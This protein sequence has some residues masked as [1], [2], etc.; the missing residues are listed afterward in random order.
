MYN[1]V[2]DADG[3]GFL[4]ILFATEIP[5]G[6]TP[7]VLTM[8]RNLGG[9]L[10]DDAATPS[11]I[12]LTVGGPTA[13]A[14][15]DNDGCDDFVMYT[16]G[17]PPWIPE[18]LSVHIS[19][20]TYPFSFTPAFTMPSPAAFTW[21][22][23]ADIDG[24][25]GENDFVMRASSSRI[26]TFYGS[27]SGI[28][29]TGPV[30]YDSGR[31]G[32]LSLA[33]FYV[34]DVDGDTKNDI[35]FCVENWPSISG[36]SCILDA[37]DASFGGSNHVILASNS[38]L[39]SVKALAWAS[40]T[41]D[42]KP[43]LV[44]ATST[45]GSEPNAIVYFPSGPGAPG[46]PS[47]L[48]STV[49]YL[50][51]PTLPSS[52]YGWTNLLVADANGD[53][54]DD[55]FAG[56]TYLLLFP[57]DPPSFFALFD[58]A[59]V[60]IDHT[61]EDNTGLG[62]ENADFIDIGFI[63][64]NL[65]PDIMVASPSTGTIKW[66]TFGGDPDVRETPFALGQTIADPVPG[67]ILAALLADVDTDGDLD[68]VF[69]TPASV[70]FYPNV[71][72]DGRF[73]P[74]AVL[75]LS[76]MDP[77][78]TPSGTLAL[79]YHAASDTVS[80]VSVASSLSLAT[81]TLSIVPFPP[82][83]LFPPTPSFSHTFPSTLVHSLTSMDVDGNGEEDLIVV[84]GASLQILINPSS[85][86]PAP[87]GNPWE[88]VFTPSIA[89]TM[90]D[91][92]VVSSGYV[93]SDATPDLVVSNG[94]S[95]YW[96]SYN[97]LTSDWDTPV[98]IVALEPQ[99]IPLRSHVLA[100]FDVD[101]T[102]QFVVS[103]LNL[104][105]RYSGDSDGLSWTGKVLRE[106]DGNMPL[107]H[108]TISYLMTSDVDT[109]G[110]LDLVF[111]S[112]GAVLLTG[113]LSRTESYVFA[114]QTRDAPRDNHQCA[115]APFSFACLAERIAAASRCDS[116]VDT[117]ELPGGT[118]ECSRNGHILLD[119][120][121]T[122]RPAPGQHVVFEC[123]S[124]TL[125]RIQ[126]PDVV[127]TLQNM[128]IRNM[129][130]A[131]KSLHGSPGLRVEG[132]GS[133]LILQ[134]VRI[135]HSSAL[136]S[137]SD[138]FFERGLG[139]G[140]LVMAG[141]SAIAHD[142]HFVSCTASEAGGAVAVI[143]P[144]SFFT[145]S[146]GSIVSSTAAL[147]G[148]GIY[149]GPG[150]QARLTSGVL[151]DGNEATF[152][153]GGGLYVESQASVNVSSLVIA[154]NGAVR[155]GGGGIMVRPGASVRASLVAFESNVALA[156]GAGCVL[157]EENEEH[158]LRTKSVSQLDPVLWASA[159]STL[160]SESDH[161][162]LFLGQCSFVG[163][164]A[165]WYGGGLMACGTSGH[166]SLDSDSVSGFSGNSAGRGGLLESS[167]DGFVCHPHGLYV[168][169]PSSST[170]QS[171]HTSLNIRSRL[172]N[173]TV[174]VEE[175]HVDLGFRLSGEVS[176]FDAHGME[177]TYS[178][179]LLGLS[180]DFSSGEPGSRSPITTGVN[181]PVTFRA[182][183]SRAKLP[184]SALILVDGDVVSGPE[185]R[186]V[187]QAWTG[188]WTIAFVDAAYTL[189]TVSGPVST[190]TCPSTWGGK[191]VVT[192]NGVFGIVCDA[193]GVGQYQ[194]HDSLEPCV[195]SKAC[196]TYTL[197]LDA[198]RDGP[199]VCVC[200]EGYFTDG[201]RDQDGQPVCRLCPPG[202]ICMEG[203]G[204]PIPDT[205]YFAIS[206]A[207]FVECLR[208][209]ACSGGVAACATGYQGYMCNTCSPGY[210]S[211][212]YGMCVACK[213]GQK[214]E[215]LKGLVVAGLVSLGI[216]VGIGLL[217]R[218]G[219]RRVEAFKR[220]QGI[221]GVRRTVFATGLGS[222]LFT[223]QVLG[224]IGMARWGWHGVAKDMLHGLSALLLDVH[225]FGNECLFGG[226]FHTK[227]VVSVAIPLGMM[228]VTAGSMGLTMWG[229][230]LGEVARHAGGTVV[231]LFQIPLAW[232]TLALFD[233]VRLPNGNMVVESDLTTPCFDQSWMHL[234]PFALLGAVVM[235][236]TPV[237][238]YTSLWQVSVAQTATGP[239]Y[240]RLGPFYRLF[241]GR[242]AAVGLSGALL[243]R[244]VLVC[245]GLFVSQVA[246]AQMGLFL[247]V[248]LS[249]AIVVTRL[250]PY[251]VPRHNTMA[252]QTRG[253]LVAIV[254]LGA[255]TFA[256]FKTQ[257]SIPRGL[258]YLDAAAIVFVLLLALSNLKGDISARKEDARVK[259]LERVV[260]TLETEEIGHAE[261]E[262][263]LARIVKRLNTSLRG[264]LVLLDGSGDH[265]D[266]SGDHG[267]GTGPSRPGTGVRLDLFSAGP[268]FSS[269]ES[270]SSSSLYSGGA[271]GVGVGGSFDLVSFSMGKTPGSPP[272]SGSEAEVKALAASTFF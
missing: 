24:S 81:S 89:L 44:L 14:D 165:A 223:A 139:G 124:G 82:Q 123:D 163:N 268:V 188:T 140:L 210:F 174:A 98:L 217:A 128:T 97:T 7:P 53:G 261:L 266:G 253:A 29:S 16:P 245:F 150:S 234:I 62:P 1:T 105:E 243:E 209:S 74:S 13:A 197:L 233:C 103:G 26:Q 61:P 114:S 92:T 111:S 196:P 221:Q 112:E 3:D 122:L 178:Q 28:L 72:T 189:P 86:G 208:P 162:P 211:D 8:H 42:G 259:R 15:F 263:D 231:P 175:S 33:G 59:S 4:D 18:V 25:G 110:D 180:L 155:G 228:V 5:W 108:S 265:G 214:S 212:P 99:H 45:V 69:A 85:H 193:C 91:L 260:K 236:G 272:S 190:R 90:P 254:L 204:N 95:L 270:S 235:F 144:G 67:A 130:T 256:S 219:K 181:Q 47:G 192:A 143:G 135:E 51:D 34:Y 177:V 37:N 116:A 131:P 57:G 75:V 184:T 159:E 215:M 220:K 160:F 138:V 83:E 153:N 101:G 127:V 80:L 176:M 136:A 115:H 6:G 132:S 185:A 117:I 56:P 179:S 68:V 262:A 161:T 255:A 225:W 222:V 152:G 107:D 19:D 119:F 171:L 247:S 239:F 154:N 226:G 52:T 168:G 106:G 195:I 46:T 9:A 200:E 206:N 151:L 170:T 251:F 23:T 146:G 213:S 201:E 94:S 76:S 149:V 191:E 249:S 202:G 104:L 142:S 250:R 237:W 240:A 267:D 27:S 147:H 166:V 156:G 121:V 102:T 169:H 11:G 194:K 158:V 148:G 186:S 50:F 137:A 60:V 66:Y 32:G 199:P 100:D 63:D 125:F 38:S 71:D 84:A 227:Y 64:D 88:P 218:S 93:N 35:T 241:R 264:E 31:D 248:F 167:A 216:G 269:S 207:S 36:V 271:S 78:F 65:L 230:S 134:H 12:G 164:Q 17:S 198:P 173:F 246:L 187:T 182:L 157:S 54:F 242:Y 113:Y 40:I 10:F 20:C 183:R 96:T 203:V 21:L 172:A 30:H 133:Q 41:P 48:L 120:S 77:G 229:S 244:V 79:H 49:L 141:G 109:D 252:V 258:E 126:G 118:W 73:D 87:S 58:P 43:D 70:A 22:E 205:G 238:V 55:I 232:A 39:P 2:L 257:G 129:G 224:L 145:M